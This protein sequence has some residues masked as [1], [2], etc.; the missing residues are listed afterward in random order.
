MTIQ[1]NRRSLIPISEEVIA[2][3][4]DQKMKDFARLAHTITDFLFHEPGDETG[5]GLNIVQQYARGA[6]NASG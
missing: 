4:F 2:A 5:S 6:R 3:E 1:M